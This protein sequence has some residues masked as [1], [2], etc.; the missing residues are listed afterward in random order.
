MAEKNTAIQQPLSNCRVI[1]EELISTNVSQLDASEI[2]ITFRDKFID[3]MNDMDEIIRYIELYFRF[4]PL[5]L[6]SIFLIPEYGDT[7][8]IH[9]HGIIRG[10]RK[11]IATLL[12]WLKR[13][14]G[15]STIATIRN[16]TKYHKYLLKENP[17]EYIYIDYLKNN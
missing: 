13:R 17:K 2:T 6:T 1:M 12:L 11:D 15:R 5:K 4:I 3:S 14:F 7:N 9:F 8:R 10:K 16:T